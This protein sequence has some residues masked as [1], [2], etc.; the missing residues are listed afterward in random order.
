MKKFKYKL[1]GK[2]G[3]HR[4]KTNCCVKNTVSEFGEFTQTEKVRKCSPYI[5]FL[6]P[7]VIS[8]SVIRVKH[9]T[10]CSLFIRCVPSSET[11]K[12][13]LHKR[14]WTSAALRVM[15][16]QTFAQL[17]TTPARCGRRKHVVGFLKA[18]RP[19]GHLTHM[20]AFQKNN[21]SSAYLLM[22]NVV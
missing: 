20:R 10:V 21:H 6:S 13:Q 1:N 4:N 14:W 5:S 12:H 9:V 19:S 3:I 18:Q 16:C 7:S 22:G 2:N 15:K 11:A 17:L 8:R